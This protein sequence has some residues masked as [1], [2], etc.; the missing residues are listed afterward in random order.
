MTA[1]SSA[2]GLGWERHQ[3]LS[4]RANHYRT[5][6]ATATAAAARNHV[7]ISS[8]S[9]ARHQRAIIYSYLAFKFLLITSC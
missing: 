3:I 6:T 8:N 4:R 7:D 1:R 2:G 5:T 9:D